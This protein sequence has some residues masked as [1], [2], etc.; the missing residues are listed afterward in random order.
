MSNRETICVGLLLFS[1]SGMSNCAE[2]TP[3][4]LPKESPTVQQQPAAKALSNHDDYYIKFEQKTRDISPAKRKKF[5]TLFLNKLKN[6][7]STDE[8]EH[9]FRIVKILKSGGC[10]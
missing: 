6:A 8:E 7:S 1:I 9:Y 5:I 2:L 10:K 4:H 3:Y